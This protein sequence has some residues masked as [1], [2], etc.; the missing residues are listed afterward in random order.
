MKDA[1]IVSALSLVPRNRGAAAMGWTARTR[2]SSWFTGLF[3]TVYGVNMAEA[4]HPRSAYPTLEALFTRRLKEGARPIDDTP[5]AIV[6]PV[7]GTCAFVGPSTDGQI[8]IA[9]GRHLSLSQLVG[10]PLDGE[11]DAVVLYLSPTDYHRV[12]VPREGRATRWAYVPGTLWPVF[13]AAV[14]T[15]DGLFARNERL[16]VTVQTDAGPLDVVLVGAFGVGRISSVV[17]DIISNAGATAA[18]GEVDLALERGGDLG[19]FHLGSTVV[20]V[21]PPGAWRWSVQAGD[22]VRMGKAIG[23]AAPAVAS[24]T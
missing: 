18:T 8:E 22:T 3:V 1:L 24:A 7:D 20:L 6:S 19:V 21:A 10:R 16:T 12:H 9:P 15:I 23:S 13:P 5:E 4:E 2:V 17:T 11:H 14:R